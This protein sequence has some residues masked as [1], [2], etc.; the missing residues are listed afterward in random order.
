[1]VL[2]V[3]AQKLAPSRDLPNMRSNEWS[4][5]GR[6]SS[7]CKRL[8]RL[9]QRITRGD[10]STQMRSMRANGRSTGMSMVKR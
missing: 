10:G 1:M 3:L 2:Q 8:Y 6:V 5:S 9:V 7:K 4:Q